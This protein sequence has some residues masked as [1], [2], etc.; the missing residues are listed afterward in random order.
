V[1][2]AARGGACR[3]GNPETVEEEVERRQKAKLH[4][5]EAGEERTG[6][7]IDRERLATDGD[8]SSPKRAVTLWI[9]REDDE[10]LEGLTAERE[11]LTCMVKGSEATVLS[12]FPP[13]PE[14]KPP[15]S[16]FAEGIY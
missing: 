3:A 6:V 10:H 15:H 11:L 8:G 7:E 12:R 14:T 5:R 4:L 2:G 13:G 9:V 1:A 16:L